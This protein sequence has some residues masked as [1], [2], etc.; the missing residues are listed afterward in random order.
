MMT[1]HQE[2]RQFTDVDPVHSCDVFIHSTLPGLVQLALSQQN[3]HVYNNYY[4][5]MIK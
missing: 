1:G 2:P 4:D 3:H 5:K